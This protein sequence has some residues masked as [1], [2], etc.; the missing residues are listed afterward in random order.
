MQASQGRKAGGDGEEGS[1]E[2]LLRGRDGGGR[3]AEGDMGVTQKE[4]LA[5]YA[6]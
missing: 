4:V 3:C 2:G 5:Y 6:T 1:I